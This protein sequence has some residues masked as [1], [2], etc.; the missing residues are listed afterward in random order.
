LLTIPGWTVVVAGDAVVTHE[1]FEA[2]RVF[3]QV[4]DV[5]E[6]QEAFAGILEI[7]DEIIPGH[8]N[9]FHVFGR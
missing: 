7:A 6:A 5:N 9:V 4:A 8:D 3:E 2:G 1:Y